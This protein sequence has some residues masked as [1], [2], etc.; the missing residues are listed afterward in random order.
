MQN[1]IV[2]DLDNTITTDSSSSDYRTKLPNPEVILAIKNAA[3]LELLT[4][5]YSS[6][7]MR[8]YK[9]DV[10]KIDTITRPIAE[11]WLEEKKI[12][13]SELILGKPW[14]GN[15][16]WYVDDRNLNIEEFIF[17][18]TSPFWKKKIDLIIPFFNEEKNVEKVHLQNK[19]AERLL[20][21]NNYIYVDNGSSD[22]TRKELNLL[23]KKDSK[24]KLVFLDKNLG[25]GDG[26]KAALKN[27]SAE[28]IVL[29]HADLQF[30]LYNFIYLNEDTLK[31]ANCLNILPKRINRSFVESVSSAFLRTLLS[32]IFKKKILDF[33]GQPKIFLKSHVG[34]IDQL[35][36]NFC[37]DLAIYM[38]IHKNSIK[39]PVI[40]NIR[41][42][43]ASSWSKSFK[44]RLSIFNQ[45]I[46]WA[47]RNK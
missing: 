14:C 42:V 11:N 5:I 38:K 6:R 19:K 39:M 3:E 41:K 30:D 40:Q 16:G 7:N 10:K 22:N 2:V 17:K 23:A 13:Y 32:L 12:N 20:N 36:S 25:Y 33:N 35:P 47:L 26:I 24:I 43:G 18:F 46:L 27:S 9:D 37:I 34:S 28:I 29:N 8:T 15:E 21:I 44:L 45:Y 4:V 1:K 31:K